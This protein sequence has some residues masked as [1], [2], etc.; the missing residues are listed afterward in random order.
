MIKVNQKVKNAT[1]KK[2]V[3]RGIDEIK[4]NAKRGMTMTELVF[5]I[6]IYSDVRNKIDEY[7]KAKKIE[8]TWLVMSGPVGMQ[9]SI[10][11]GNG[12][13]MKFKLKS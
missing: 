2:E 4:A 6:E 7:M 5:G 8:Y 11:C 3:K 12:R 13:L 10:A 9:N 1:I